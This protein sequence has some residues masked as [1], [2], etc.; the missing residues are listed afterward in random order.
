[1]QHVI[2]IIR[3]PK[4]WRPYFQEMTQF[5]KLFPTARYSS[6]FT[7]FGLF[8][9]VA[10]I[11]SSFAFAPGAWRPRGTGHNLGSWLGIRQVSRVV[12]LALDYYPE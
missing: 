9:L 7:D 1:M 8:S 5:W 2:D 12:S 10:V 11:T 4:P 6:L 3:P